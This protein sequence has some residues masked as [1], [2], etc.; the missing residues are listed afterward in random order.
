MLF[1]FRACNSNDTYKI[2]KVLGQ[3]SATH[4]STCFN[5]DEEIQIPI[6]FSASN[7]M[8]TKSMCKVTIYTIQYQKLS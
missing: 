1:H 4:P 3:C 8:C 7:N 5:A 6:Q 2:H